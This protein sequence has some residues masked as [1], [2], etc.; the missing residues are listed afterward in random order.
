V[1]GGPAVTG[2]VRIVIVGGSFGGLTTA[3]EL[4]R[5]LGPERAEITVVAKDERFCF[6]PSFP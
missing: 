6:V 5:H 3:Y 2:Q 4:R 1:G